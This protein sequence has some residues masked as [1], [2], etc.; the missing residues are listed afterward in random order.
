MRAIPVGLTQVI[1]SHLKS[2]K[3]KS[4]YPAL[5][6]G[7]IDILDRKCKIFQT[8]RKITP[9]G[10]FYWDSFITNINWRKIY[11]GYINHKIIKIYPVNLSVSKYS[12]V[13]ES[14]SF[15]G[16]VEETA[17]HLF[18]D[19]GVTK[20]LW[21]DYVSNLTNM[22]HTF[23]LKDVIFYYENPK[24]LPV[25]YVVN[26]IILNAKFFIHK[27]KWLKSPLS[28]PLFLSEFVSLVS[29]LRLTNNKKSAKFLMHCDSFSKMV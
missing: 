5:R 3:G 11:I 19:C 15:C 13:D 8:K 21:V 24:L 16:F 20:K 29:S 12:D 14:C 6:L 28:F 2:S 22:T 25:E 17:S 9:R 7:G 23:V 4:F 10:K 1:K 26:F 27:Q 18:F